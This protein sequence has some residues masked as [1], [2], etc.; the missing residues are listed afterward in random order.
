MA[1]I[2]VRLTYVAK[3][4][5]FSGRPF[6][7][8]PSCKHTKYAK[9]E[10]PIEIVGAGEGVAWELSNIQPFRLKPRGADRQPI[11]TRP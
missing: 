5:S 1:G 10:A 2:L 11:G 3:A 8:G 9:L 7:H 6:I 4:N